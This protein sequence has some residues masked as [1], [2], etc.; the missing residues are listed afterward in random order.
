MT[1]ADIEFY[2]YRIISGNLLF[3]HDNVEYELYSPSPIIRYKANLV[4]SNVIEQEKYNDWFREENL[5]PIIIHL[6]LWPKDAVE[7]IK[8]LEKKSDDQKLEL[9]KSRD[10]KSRVAFARKNLNFTRNQLNKLLSIKSDFFTN[11]LE[12]YASSIK[13]EYIVSKTLYSNNSIVFKNKNQS[14]KC[15]YQKFIKLVNIINNNVI[16]Y[17]THKT[18]ARSA[19]WRAYWN[20]NKKQ[21][22]K[23]CVADWTDDQRTLVGISQM[24]DSVYEHPES[25][26]ESVIQDSDMLDGWMI[27]QRRKVEREKKQQ[28]IESQ[29]SK[30]GNATE[31][32]LMAGEDGMSAEDILDLNDAGARQK[33]KEKFAYINQHGTVQESELPEVKRELMNQ[34]AEL[35]KSRK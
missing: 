20:C 4:Y 9:Y 29:N 21:V 22:F 17:E 24:Y 1:D 25:P 7:M 6:G 32:F 11:T 31:V 34:Q 8:K 28:N 2:I 10:T 23:G 5:V 14:D 18:I 35:L 26:S 13:N 15:S 33:M 12:G 30:L 27:Y 16:N 19:L 3:M